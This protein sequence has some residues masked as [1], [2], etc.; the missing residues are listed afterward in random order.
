MPSTTPVDRFAKNVPVYGSQRLQKSRTSVG[1]HWVLLFFFFCSLSSVGDF[2]S[3]PVS[4]FLFVGCFVFF[5]KLHQK[6]IC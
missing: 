1:G 3:V 6:Y 5:K 4:L 2:V